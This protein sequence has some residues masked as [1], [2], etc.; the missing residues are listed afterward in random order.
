[1]NDESYRQVQSLW[2]DQSCINCFVSFEGAPRR[3]EAH[4]PI[5]PRVLVGK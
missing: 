2:Y 4:L 3:G 1:M 5:A